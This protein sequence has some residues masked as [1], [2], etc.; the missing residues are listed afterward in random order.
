[1]HLEDEIRAGRNEL[2]HAV[3][4]LVGRATG[5]VDQQKIAGCLVRLPPLGWIIECGRG[6]GLSYRGV[7]QPWRIWR[8]NVDHSMMHMRGTSRTKLRH[9][10]PPVLRKVRRDDFVGVLDFPAR[11]NVHRL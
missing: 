5:S 1:M 4:P 8:T 10:H 6:E 9:L 7:P 2:R 11:W 3:R